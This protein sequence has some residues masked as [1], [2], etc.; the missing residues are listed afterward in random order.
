V[1]CVALGQEFLS[2]GGSHKIGGYD[3]AL[4]AS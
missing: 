1:R 4:K 2:S 3:A